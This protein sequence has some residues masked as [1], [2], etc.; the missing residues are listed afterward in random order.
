MD[1]YLPMHKPNPRLNLL[2]PHAEPLTYSDCQSNP[3]D[4]GEDPDPPVV[5]SL[6]WNFTKLALFGIFRIYINGVLNGW[7]TTNGDSGAFPLV[8]GDTI[9]VDVVGASGKPKRI[10]VSNDVDGVVSDTTSTL[11]T[12]TY[13]FV[14]DANKNYSVVGEANN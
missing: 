11:V 3:G 8:T 1:K 2:L 4:G 10:F 13:T 7:S 5:Y 14:V 6:N 12:H 9:K